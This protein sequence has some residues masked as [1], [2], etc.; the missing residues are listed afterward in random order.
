MTDDGPVERRL[1]SVRSAAAATELSETTIRRLARSGQL[2]SVR[3]GD[4]VLFRP[5]DIDAMIDEAA[6]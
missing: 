4:R 3:I 6:S 2:R 5:A 1:L